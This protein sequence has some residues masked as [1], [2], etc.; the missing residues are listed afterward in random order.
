MSNDDHKDEDFALFTQE[1]RLKHEI[2]Y[3]QE[4]VSNLES[5]KK[6]FFIVN[7]DLI[8]A[9][10]KLS[11]YEQQA[12]L[13]ELKKRIVRFPEIDVS[14][15]L[16]SNEEVLEFFEESLLAESY[17]DLVMSIFQSPGRNALTGCDTNYQW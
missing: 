6:K 9:R 2:N 13:D 11:L 1:G 14:D 12:S 5:F 7:S 8:R 15:D 17:Q 10:E 4:R 16:A 3:L